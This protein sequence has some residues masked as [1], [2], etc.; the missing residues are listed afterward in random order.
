MTGRDIGRAAVLGSPIAHSLSPVLHRAAYAALG[1]DGW[2]YDA[3]EVDDEAFPAWFDEA[4]GRTHEHGDIPGWAGLSLT[5]PLKRVV[6]PLL[7]RV[8]PLADGI[9]SVN[10]VVFGEDGTAQGYNTDVYGIVAALAEAGVSRVESAAVLG[11][12]ATA[13]S[14][15]CA[16]QLIGCEHADVY[17]RSPERARDLVTAGE[18]LGAAPRIHPLGDLE[19]GPEVDVIVST[20][21]PGAADGLVETL[22]VSRPRAALLDV[23]YTPWPT[24]LARVREAL[25]P[26]RVV[27]G[28]SMLLH[29]AA[30]Q[31]EL[32]TGLKA[33]VSA[34]AEALRGA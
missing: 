13:A 28:A 20:L 21:P 8:D 12:G 30:A 3:Y 14:A 34:M 15:I 31:V 9:G 25:T 16:L 1:L 27:G 29:Q 2:R 23:V 5:M 11:A 32:M 4:R 19:G 24:H 6:I 17:A 22:G 26:G 10:T 33:P 7:D 18:A